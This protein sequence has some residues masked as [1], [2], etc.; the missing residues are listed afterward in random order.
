[1][2]NKPYLAVAGNRVY[3]TDPEGYRVLIFDQSGG[4]VATFGEYGFDSKTFSLP[5]GIAVDGEGNIYV[6]DSTNHR[7]MKFAP[8]R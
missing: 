8:V 6:T 5:T 1:V 7:V 4:F 3:V 2:V